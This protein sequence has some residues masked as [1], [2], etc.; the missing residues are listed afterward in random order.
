M[1]E[2]HYIVELDLLLVMFVVVEGYEPNLNDFVEEFL[3][4]NLIV[5][6]RHVRVFELKAIEEKIEYW[7]N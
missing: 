7:L 1:F 4:L 3:E 5:D 6:N 2:N